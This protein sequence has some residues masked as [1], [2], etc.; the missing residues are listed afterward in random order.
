ML[1][2]YG[3][4]QPLGPV[5]V[6][7]YLKSCHHEAMEFSASV[8]RAS[9]VVLAQC[10]A[11]WLQRQQ[12]RQ[13]FQEALPEAAPGTGTPPLDRSPSRLELVHGAE[14]RHH[15]PSWT[16]LTDPEGRAA[17]WARVLPRLPGQAALCGQEA[18]HLASGVLARDD[19]SADS[20][21]P[22]APIAHSRKHPLKKMMKRTQSFEMPQ[23]DGSPGGSRWPGHTAVLIRRLEVTGPLAS[24]KPPPRPHAES[25]WDARNWGL[26]SS[27]RTRPSEEDQRRP[28]GR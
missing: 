19:S 14:A 15:Q 6:A 27:S 25:P 11:L 20:S 12:A 16:P 10:H 17:E 5:Q 28:A 8:P 24:E 21:E 1:C 9:T 26:S 13:C 7:E 2:G 22:R 4:L 3:C 23:L 18:V